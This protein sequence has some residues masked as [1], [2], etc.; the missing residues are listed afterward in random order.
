MRRTVCPYCGHIMYDP[1]DGI[2]FRCI[3]CKHEIP[4]AE[5]EIHEK[6]KEFEK[7]LNDTKKKGV[8]CNH[9]SYGKILQ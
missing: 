4:D 7:Y 2:R 1:G 8:M 6:I 9:N 3:F 5:K